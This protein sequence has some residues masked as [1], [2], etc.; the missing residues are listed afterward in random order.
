M[1]QQHYHCITDHNSR[2]TLYSFQIVIDYWR[3]KYETT[4]DKISDQ[5]GLPRYIIT[6]PELYVVLP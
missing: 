4:M 3:G 6:V 5:D 2:I 1:T